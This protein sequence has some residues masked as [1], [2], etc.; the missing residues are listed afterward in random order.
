L[1]PFGQANLK[2]FD[3]IVRLAGG[4]RWENV[5][6]KIDDFHTLASTSFV[7]CSATVTTNCGESTYGGV[8]VAG[9]KPKFDDLL[10]NGGVI[11]EPLAGIRAYASYA[12]GFTVPD[13]GRITRSIRDTRIDF[14]NFLVST[15]V[16]PNKRGWGCEITRGPLVARAAYFWS[17]SDRGQLLV[18]GSDRMFDVQRLRV[19]IE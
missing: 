6:I 13:I 17:T 18:T 7:P 11:G 4:V 12:E 2:L 1:A 14:V 8:D 16:V 19:E 3:G 15:P 9:G 5:T 10:V